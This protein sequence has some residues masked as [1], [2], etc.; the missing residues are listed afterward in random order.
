MRSIFF[1]TTTTVYT[2]AQV[3]QQIPH[4]QEVFSKIPTNDSPKVLIIGLDQKFF[5]PNYNPTEYG[6]EDIS[7]LL[8]QKSMPWIDVVGNWW[9]KWFAVY[10][11]YLSLKIPPLKIINP[12]NSLVGLGAVVY[13]AG[14]RNDG[15]YN[16]SLWHPP[17]NDGVIPDIDRGIASFEYSNTISQNSIDE[18][19]SFLA[20]CRARNIYVIGF[21]P[22]FSP[23]A[24]HEISSL[25]GKYGYM[26]LISPDVGAVFK[27]YNFGFYNFTD[28][29]SIGLTQQGMRDNLH[30]TEEGSLV[31]F[32][33]MAETNSVLQQYTNINYLKQRLNSLQK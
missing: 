20:E 1:N 17:E 9:P 23:E 4:F 27:K 26:N 11:Y 10:Y 13:G 2:A 16:L 31:Y 5:D 30:T 18:L 15:S 7:T 19:G 24:Y 6:A 28:P 12:D 8:T 33:K 25:S 32:L 29:Q 3:I 22:P 21:V 14:F